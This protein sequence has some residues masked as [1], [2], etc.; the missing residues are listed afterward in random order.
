ME[1]EN[2][3]RITVGEDAFFSYYMLYHYFKVS[4]IRQKFKNSPIAKKSTIQV[5]DIILDACMK[6]ESYPTKTVGGDRFWKIV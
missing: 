1:F 2:Y 6:F 3:P 4:K 5:A